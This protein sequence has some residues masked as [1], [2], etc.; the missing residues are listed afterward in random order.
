MRFRFLKKFKWPY[1]RATTIA[2]LALIIST[3]Q[4]VTP[5]VTSF[6]ARPKLVVQGEAWHL[7]GVSGEN[8]K[9]ARFIFSLSR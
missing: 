7:N 2:V 4:F 3:L 9:G 1:D 5:L 6:Y 8:K